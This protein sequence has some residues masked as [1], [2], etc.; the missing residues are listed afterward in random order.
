MSG[1][2]IAQAP[3]PGLHSTKCFRYSRQHNKQLLI[4]KHAK[5]L[6]RDGRPYALKL[7]G[8]EKIHARTVVIATGAQYRKLAKYDGR[9]G[10]VFSPPTN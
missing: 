10:I 4:S 2:S 3:L 9:H 1:E 5:G 7:D 8:E 6:A